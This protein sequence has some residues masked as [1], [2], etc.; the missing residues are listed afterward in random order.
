MVMMIVVIGTSN[1]CSGSFVRKRK[2]D[3]KKTKKRLE[4][5]VETIMI[6]WGVDRKHVPRTFE[7]IYFPV[8]PINRR[9]NVC[10]HAFRPMVEDFQRFIDFVAIIVLNKIT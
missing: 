4:I 9:V 8:S 7:E 5:E 10:P 3:W 1:D 6:V 2:K